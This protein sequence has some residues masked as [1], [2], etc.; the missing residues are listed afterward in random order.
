MLKLKNKKFQI[1]IEL[2]IN[3]YLTKFWCTHFNYHSHKYLKN[4]ELK[5]IDSNIGL[6]NFENVTLFCGFCTKNWIY[7]Y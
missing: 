3:N 4:L 7:R 6:W 5:N 1:Q 2:K